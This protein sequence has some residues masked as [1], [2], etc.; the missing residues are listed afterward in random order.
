[1]LGEA[2]M[3]SARR[4]NGAALEGVDLRRRRFVITAAVTA[5]GAAAELGVIGPAQAQSGGTRPSA[6]PAVGPG[7]SASFGAPRQVSAGVLD[8]GYAEAGPTDGPAVILLHGWPYDIHS[9]V[10]V[11]PTLAA[12]GYRVIVPYLRG[13][14]STSRAR[15]YATGSRR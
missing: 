15:R 10:E 5:A 12:A 2:S 1:M 14:G 4:P 3:C 6:L 13:Y 9:Y 7:A 8:V 11:A